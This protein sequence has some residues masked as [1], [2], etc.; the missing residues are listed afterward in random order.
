M[1]EENNNNDSYLSSVGDSADSASN[2][3]VVAVGSPKSGD[4]VN[5]ARKSA[6]KLSDRAASVGV[7]KTTA[8]LLT[9][10]IDSAVVPTPDHEIKGSYQLESDKSMDK[11][12]LPLASSTNEAEMCA[13]S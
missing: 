6:G 3:H 2:V 9:P 7:V 11:D 8:L 4:L 10:M 12:M 1:C 5:S 13:H